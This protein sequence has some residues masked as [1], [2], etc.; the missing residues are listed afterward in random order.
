MS[1]VAWGREDTSI[2]LVDP[3]TWASI[4][5]ALP[6]KAVHTRDLTSSKV[7]IEFLVST[8]DGGIIASVEKKV[9]R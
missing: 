5:R 2:S 9:L 8:K 3:T 4:T 7:L 1:Y 6:T